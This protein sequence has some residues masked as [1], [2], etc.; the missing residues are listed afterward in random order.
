MD[1]QTW[2]RK[3]KDWMAKELQERQGDLEGARGAIQP[4]I[5]EQAIRELYDVTAV[6][7]ERLNAIEKKS[8]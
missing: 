6:L 8:K 5:T 4:A 3:R 2:Q 7:E 1:R